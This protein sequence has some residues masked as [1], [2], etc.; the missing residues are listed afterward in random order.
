[1]GGQQPRGDLPP[2]RWEEARLTGARVVGQPASLTDSISQRQ[3]PD[4]HQ[5]AKGVGDIGIDH[6]HPRQAENDVVG[7]LHHAQAEEADYLGKQRFD[8]KGQQT[9]CNS[10]WPYQPGDQQVNF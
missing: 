5:K 9:T 4:N 10:E 2:L 6:D 7:H 8:L 1:M 3:Q